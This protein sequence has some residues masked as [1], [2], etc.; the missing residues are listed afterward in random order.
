[1]DHFKELIGRSVLRKCE[2]V[3]K[4]KGTNFEKNIS[5]ETFIE[6]LK[7]KRTFMQKEKRKTLCN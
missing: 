6:T 7:K 3:T 1:M 4:N 2:N 5:L